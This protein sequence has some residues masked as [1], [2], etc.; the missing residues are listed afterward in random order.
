MG[1]ALPLCDPW[2]Y[3][4]AEVLSQGA[5]G[6]R[7]LQLSLYRPRQLCRDLAEA[8]ATSLGGQVAGWPAQRPLPAR[9]A[10]FVNAA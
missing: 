2:S 8:I 9:L 10:P 3:L 1:V 7:R 4:H 6:E 5:L